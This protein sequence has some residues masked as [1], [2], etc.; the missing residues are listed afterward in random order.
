MDFNANTMDPKEDVI[1]N[2]VVWLEVPVGE[3]NCFRPPTPQGFYTN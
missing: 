3:S 1:N 2:N